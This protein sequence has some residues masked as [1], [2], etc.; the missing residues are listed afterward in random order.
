[1]NKIYALK[2]VR[3][4][5][6]AEKPLTL[7]EVKLHLRV[8]H[9]DEDTLIE[10]LLDASVSHLDGWGGILGRC[11]ITQTWRQDIADF[12]D[13]IRLP[14]TD[15][16]SATIEYSDADN[17][18][19]S[20]TEF[21]LV[22]DSLGSLL[23]LTDGATWPDVATRPDAVR[24]TV[25]Y[26]YGNAASVPWAI[27]AAILLHVGTLYENRETLSERVSPNMAYEALIAPLRLVSL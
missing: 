1:M 23:S 7:P 12:C 3:T 19:Q 4:V 14:F 5:A 20:F 16:Q 25:V 6:P 27:K 22:S 17:A 15:A 21:N 11:L 24:I 13:P 18:P 26:G 2:P 8:D 10:G 9:S